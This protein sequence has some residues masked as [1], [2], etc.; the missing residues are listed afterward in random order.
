M[1]DGGA[2]DIPGN[3]FNVSKALPIR[4]GGLFVKIWGHFLFVRFKNKI[5]KRGN[6]PFLLKSGGSI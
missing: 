5:N 1:R 4:G 3:I 2:R 6:R